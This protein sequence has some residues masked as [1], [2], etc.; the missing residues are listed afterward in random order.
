MATGIRIDASEVARNLGKLQNKAF[1]GLE[2][3]ALEGARKF[4]NYAKQHARWKNR[5]GQARQRL[6][7]YV[8]KGT[9]YIRVNI[10]HGVDY[11]KWLEL[12]NNGKYGILLDTVFVNGGSVLQTMQGYINRIKV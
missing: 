12:A 7:G 5:T 4:E 1:L 2:A 9:N 8:S 11:G 3:L 10:A 6:N